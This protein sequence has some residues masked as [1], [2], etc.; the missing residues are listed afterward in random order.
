MI[1]RLLIAASM[2]LAVAFLGAPLGSPGQSLRAAPVEAA[3]AAT[4][5]DGIAV[6]HGIT[7]D[8]QPVHE[9]P[10]YSKGTHSVWISFNYYDHDSRAK[11]TYLARANGDD[12]KWGSLD[13]CKGN[14]GRFAFEFDGKNGHDLPG[15]AY[16]V[17][18][19]VNGAEVA[20]VGFG[21]KGKGGLDHGDPDSD[22]H[23][24]GNGN[25]N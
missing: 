24:N 16:D 23:G 19:Y 14:S 10:E 25:G 9:D 2:L 4:Y 3:P 5:T 6:S 1:V 18:I 15:A 12:Y 22:D 17:R 11:V 8:G 13:C 20:Q 21:V 7:N